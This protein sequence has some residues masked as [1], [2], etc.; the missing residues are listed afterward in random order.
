MYKYL[1]KGSLNSIFKFITI[2]IAMSIKIY[3]SKNLSIKLFNL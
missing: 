1:K 3:C 2:A